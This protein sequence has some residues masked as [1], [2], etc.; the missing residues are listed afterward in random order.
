MSRYLLNFA[1]RSL[2]KF[3]LSGV[4]LASKDVM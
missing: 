1:R 2:P 4:G 3:M